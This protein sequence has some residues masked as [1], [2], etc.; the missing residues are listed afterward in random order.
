MLG[1]T[2][3]LSHR[4]LLL[5][6]ITAQK[7]P[8]N[9]Y[10]IMQERSYCSRINFPVSETEQFWRKMLSQLY[11]SKPEKSMLAYEVKD[12][13]L[14]ITFLFGSN[15]SSDFWLKSLPCSSL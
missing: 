2:Q 13:L 12:S 11:N 14:F 1:W 15:I 8:L 6:E 3:L 4:K 10:E 9:V 7:V 5:C